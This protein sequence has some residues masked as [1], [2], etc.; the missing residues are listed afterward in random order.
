MW[1]NI[2]LIKEYKHNVVL[3]QI[4]QLCLFLGKP[5]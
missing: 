2:D 4:K 1:L 3:L 5:E